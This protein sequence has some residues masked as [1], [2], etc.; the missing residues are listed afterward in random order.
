M[1]PIS[2]FQLVPSSASPLLVYMGGCPNLPADSIDCNVLSKFSMFR[3]TEYY[4]L[5]VN[6]KE[7]LPLVPFGGRIVDI[8]Y[9]RPCEDYLSL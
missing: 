1:S 3:T 9:L 6:V 8:L 2:K 7:C 5:T 4:V